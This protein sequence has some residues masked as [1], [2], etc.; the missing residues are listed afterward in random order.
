MINFEPLNKDKVKLEGA[1]LV[2][3][4]A[5][6]GKTYSIGLLVLRLI[7]EKNI[8]ISKILLVT[9]TKSAVAELAARVRRFIREAVKAS[10]DGESE[11]ITITKY[12]V[13]QVNKEEVIKR[14]K[15]AL[16]DLDEASIQTIHSF[17]QES[18]NNYSLHSGQPFGLELQPNV[19]SIAQN[20][21]HEFWRESV[22]VLPIEDLEE[23]G[24]D[25]CLDVFYDA[26]KENL[27]GKEFAFVSEG[28]AEIYRKEVADFQS[29]LKE[30]REDL[31]RRIREIKVNNFVPKKQDEI[32]E[33]LEDI[34]GFSSW[35]LNNPN[36]AA[37]ITNCWIKIFPEER[38]KALALL[39]HHQ[40]VVNTLIGKCIKEVKLKVD[41]YLQE[42]H[43]I[44][45]DEII[46]RMHSEVIKG[47]DEEKVNSLC[48]A[49]RNQFDAVFI[50]EFQDTDRMQYEIYDTL[51]GKGKI[52][53]YI[54]D[55]KQ[56]IYGWRK[57]DLNTYFTARKKI[58]KEKR[59]KMNINYR[60]SD[61]YVEA[62][63]KFYAPLEDPF[64][65][66]GVGDNDIQYYDVEA[67]GSNKR[68]L[69]NNE[70]NVNAL[71]II[72]EQTK[73]KIKVKTLCLVQELLN[74]QYTIGSE[75]VK[76]S[77][78][79]ILVRANF[80][81]REIQSLLIG[82]GIPA[83]T[84]D[85]SKI[86]E[87]SVEAVAL[88]NILEA[89]ITA[90]EYTLK[91]AL[92]CDFTGYGYKDLAQIEIEDLL[93]LFREYRETWTNSGVYAALRLF[94]GHFNVTRVLMETNNFRSLTNL[95]QI[96]ELLQDAEF[97]QEL[98]PIGLY[99][100][101]QKQ[102]NG[103]KEEDDEFQQRIESDEEAIKIITIHK[104]KGLE[105]PIVIAPL[106]DLKV[107]EK[108]NFCSFRD[109]EGS[110][111][112]YPSKKGSEEM[113]Q[114]NKIQG[115][116]ENRRLIYVALTRAKF[117]CFLF[118]TPIKKNRTSLDDFI[119]E[120]VFDPFELPE[121]PQD[122]IQS[123]DDLPKWDSSLAKKFTLT[124]EYY[125]KLSF[126]ALS[127]HSSH[128]LSEK[129]DK[130]ESKYDQ[131]IF[132][133]IPGGKNMGTML[134]YLFENIDFTNP[135]DHQAEV[136]KLVNRYYP[137]KKELL[138][139]RLVEMVD[140]VL[141]SDIR[142]PDGT[143]I[144]LKDLD[145]FNKLNEMEFDFNTSDICLKDLKDFD[146]G[147]GIEINCNMAIG[148]KKGLLT[149]LID[150]FFEHDGKY[151][152]LDW[153]SNF[154]GD[155]LEH[156]AK[157]DIMKKALN[158]GNYHLQYLIYSM[159]VKNYLE[160]RL[161]NF[162]YDKHFGGVI[163]IY[164]RGARKGTEHGIYTNRPTLEQVEA[165]ELIFTKPVTA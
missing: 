151:Y 99:S 108:Y 26:V 71:E 88:L 60:S 44:T 141:H 49:I 82:A 19:L 38:K 8:P 113:T 111:K 64:I 112:F 36:D 24:D 6:T 115:E 160:A 129:L 87:D 124:D 17:C 162:D 7:L 116:Q 84:V 32:I 165:L 143:S 122:I 81:G 106:L 134:H 53:F 103:V 56:S 105:Y 145:S 3:A 28:N 114:F 42:K 63:N 86:F 94:M 107:E 62:I 147:K 46:K 43:L 126:S 51:F 35:L 128:A 133:D 123:V 148:T 149:G 156:Y 39:R 97:K 120:L 157:G 67:F 98:K 127:P 4:S 152:I 117:N 159:A 155:S 22:A 92:L 142:F 101:L 90:N 9:F 154:L 31:I 109:A 33:L 2:E 30:N 125:G 85:E 138:R 5:G 130:Y 119:E 1:N 144:V 140:N 59:F 163:Y 80:E 66:G 29:Y 54:G 146:L 57:A 21:V 136:D 110:Y 121:N 83:V 104:A 45:Y 91:K 76:K 95:T 52:I 48:N 55:P 23:W 77:D 11:E 70:K 47:K 72:Q 96:L 34:E 161:E 58:V 65:T 158:E 153:K 14:L 18:L 25:L 102:I 10:E 37:Y 20:Y 89:I 12:I 73:E 13:A 74:G 150:L 79:G 40:N 75:L 78:I 61:A 131:F 15:K 50:D 93:D 135:K 16:S 69:H 100:Y 41:I 164:L 137:G 118:K 68:G 27:G 132:K 139:K